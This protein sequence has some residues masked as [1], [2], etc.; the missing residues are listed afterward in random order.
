VCS[1]DLSWRPK[2]V[3]AIKNPAVAASITSF[4]LVLVVAFGPDEFVFVARAALLPALFIF[5]HVLADAALCD[6]DDRVADEHY[7]TETLPV[8]SGV[9]TTKAVALAMKV[10]A[11][12]IPFVL[13]WIS[14]LDIGVAIVWSV[15]PVVAC[16]T[17]LRFWGG[18]LRDPI[19]AM[20][21]ALCIVAVLVGF[22]R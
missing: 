19:D 7:E 12:P 10:A 8:R 14:D 15:L 4:A 21:A 20:P 3:L 5:L 16:A 11:V 17:L 18:R 9:R 2:D 22:I 13:V 6:I 1:S